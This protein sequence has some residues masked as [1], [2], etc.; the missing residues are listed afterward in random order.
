M[1]MSKAKKSRLKTQREGKLNPEIGRL[2]WTRKPITQVK[3]NTKAEQRRSQCR[4]KGSRDGAYF[5]GTVKITAVESA[6]NKLPPNGKEGAP[7]PSLGGTL[8]VYLVF[9]TMLKEEK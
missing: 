3:P 5:F 9:N 4:H 8:F 7:H 6:T 2:E 1:G